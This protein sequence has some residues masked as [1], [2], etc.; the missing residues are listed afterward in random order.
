MEEEDRPGWL[1]CSVYSL[2]LTEAG[3]LRRIEVGVSCLKGT[4][5]AKDPLTEADAL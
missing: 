4:A 5:S 2:S 1:G 3:I